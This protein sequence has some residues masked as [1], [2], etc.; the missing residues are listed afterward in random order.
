MVTDAELDEI[1]ARAKAATQG[2]WEGG[3]T[4]D[5]GGYFAV[6][7]FQDATCGENGSHAHVAA[8]WKKGDAASEQ[9]EKDQ[10][11]VNHARSDVPALVAEV[12]R[13]RAA[14]QEYVAISD[15]VRAYESGL[16]RLPK[17][18]CGLYLEHNAHRD[19]K[20]SPT[21]S[22][23]PTLGCLRMSG[24]RRLRRT[25]AGSCSGTQ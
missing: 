24:R 14:A 20:S 5:A 19:A 10:D 11:F 17:H 6:G 1:E 9:A 13:L 8:C 22:S 15:R 4:T 21:A 18:K 23:T 2:G 7:P 12:R 3:P 25:N 16:T